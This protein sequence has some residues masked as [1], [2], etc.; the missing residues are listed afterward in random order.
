MEILM[1]AYEHYPEGR[2]I[3]YSLCELSIKLQDIV[4]AIE[5][6]KEFVRIAPHNTSRYILQYK[7]Y[8]AQDVSIEERIAVLQEFKKHDYREKWGY[9]LAF[10]YHR[11]GLTT[12]CVEECDELFLWFGGG[13]Y[14]MKALELKALHEKLSPEQQRV[15]E[16]YRVGMQDPQASATKESD[17]Y[18]F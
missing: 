18:D 15:Y 13:R 9:E 4:H 12:E 16:R 11:V 1:I 17:N 2:Y 10:L 7:L 3:I 14:V 5:Y 6:F 8:V